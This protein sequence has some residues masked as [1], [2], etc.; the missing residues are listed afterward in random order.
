LLLAAAG[1]TGAGIAGLLGGL[2]YGFAGASQPL[3]P[4]MGAV[5]MLLVMVCLTI[6]A[7][8]AGGAGVSLGIAASTLLPG[9]RWRWAIAGG[10]LGGMLVGA[11]AK[12]LGLDAFNLLLGRSPGDITGGA[13]GLLLGAAVGV[14][15]WFGSRSGKSPWT[16]SSV[17]AATLATAVAGVAIPLLGGRL[18]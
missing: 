15:L 4:G 7:A 13:E 11:V 12:L 2:A 10:A 6:I 17:I 5:S 3:A 14:G 18:M 16:R 1:T 9:T 8:V